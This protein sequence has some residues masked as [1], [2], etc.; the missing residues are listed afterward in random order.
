LNNTEQ[1]RAAMRAAFPT[2]AQVV[3][4]LRGAFPKVRVLWAIEG[5]NVAG[6]VPAGALAEHQQRCREHQQ[7]K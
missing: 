3:D 1:R 2:V 5:D 4:E 7:E 6:R